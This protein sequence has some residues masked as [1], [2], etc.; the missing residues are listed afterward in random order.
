MRRPG[1]FYPYIITSTA[2]LGPGVCHHNTSHRQ[3]PHSWLPHHSQPP[4]TA[5]K[6]S[7]R[8]GLFQAAVQPF[9][10]NF[11][12]SNIYSFPRKKCSSPMLGK[13]LP[14]F[15]TSSDFTLSSSLVNDF[16]AILGYSW[17]MPCT[18]LLVLFM[19]SS[20][21]PLFPR[22]L[23]LPA[24][25]LG[26]NYTFFSERRSLTAVFKTVYSQVYLPSIAPISL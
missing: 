9:H 16:C 19:Y 24:S 14:T 22:M 18:F 13:S 23:T 12:H 6:A 17:H 3:E 2:T 10:S 1:R 8:G 7:A 25:P 4:H 26:P 21:C 15:S 5:V 20:L 11:Q